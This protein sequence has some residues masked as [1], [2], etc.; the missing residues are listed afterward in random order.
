MELSVLD[1]YGDLKVTLNMLAQ[2][3]VPSGITASTSCQKTGVG[4][5]ALLL[6]SSGSNFTVAI[7]GHLDIQ[8]SSTATLGN[9]TYN[10]I[11]D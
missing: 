11:C 5:L 8:G 10:P 3:S 2:V 4:K 9:V 1:L 6:R 7:G